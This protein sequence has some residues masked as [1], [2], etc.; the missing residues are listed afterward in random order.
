MFSST[1]FLL[2]PSAVSVV[3]AVT[4]E[5]IQY[6]SATVVDAVVC[7]KSSEG[8]YDGGQVSEPPF[9]FQSPPS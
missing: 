9:P 2:F 3:S 7:S 5:I 8:V 1:V 4:P 6:A